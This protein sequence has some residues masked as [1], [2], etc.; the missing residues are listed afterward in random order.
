[1]PSLRNLRLHIFRDAE[2]ILL[3]T[4]V[5]NGDLISVDLIEDAFHERVRYCTNGILY[6]TLI[7]LFILN[8]VNLFGLYVDIIMLSAKYCTAINISV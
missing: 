7:E 3:S 1:M 6:A 8:A 2:I 5:Y 4:F